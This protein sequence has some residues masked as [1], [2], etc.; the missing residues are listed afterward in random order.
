MLRQIGAG[1]GGAARRIMTPGI[2]SRALLF[3]LLAAASLPSSAAAHGPLVVTEGGELEGAVDEGVR[4]FRGVAYARPP[5]GALRWRAPE[6]APA[7]SDR[8]KA[9]NFSPSCPQGE[10]KPFGPYTPSFLIAGKQSE[11]CLYLNIWTPR[12]ARK[13][14]VLVFV[15]GGGFMSGGADIASYDGASLAAQGAVVATINY[16]LG[17]LGFFAHGDLAKES[18]HG[19]SG[20][21]ALLDIVA[22]LKWVKANI[23]SFGG[24]PD[25]VTIAG[26]SAG[27]ALVT[28]LLVSPLGRGLFERAVIHSGPVI[29]IPNQPLAAAEAFGATSMTRAGAADIAALRALDAEKILSAPFVGLPLPVTDGRILPAWPEAPS[30]ALASRVPVMIGYTREESDP[31]ADPGTIAAFEAEVHKRFGALA[32]R[33]LALYPHKSDE[34]AAASAQRLG[35]DRRV[36]G[37]ILWGER[38]AAEGVPVFAYHFEHVFP[39]TDPA[40]Y[41]AF[42]TADIPYF[43]GALD[44]P[45]ARF[46]ERD[47]AI[48]R[49]MQARLLAFMDSGDPGKGAA[50]DRWRRVTS[51]PASIWRID[52]ADAE[53]L[54]DSERLAL[55]RDHEARGGALG[56][57]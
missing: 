23:G 15:H 21:Y 25:N 13:R 53:P 11:D 7:W 52:P 37:M 49:S 47:R 44:L 30:T 24:D 14:P 38:R 26:Q 8:L 42:H 1:S 31:G 32:P 43:F 34:E 28:G 16:R 50:S 54:L 40:R 51:D 48:A 22:A 12:A 35:R 33:V 4:V 56:L 36:A 10:P 5:I 20:N 3:A 41:R 17:R 57:F 46:G 9:T 29:G 27:A 18:P 39:G 45:D 2:G 55:F 6:P 19:T